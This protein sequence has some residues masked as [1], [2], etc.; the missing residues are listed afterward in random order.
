MADW[1]KI[2]DRYIS[3]EISLAQLAREEGVSCTT[4]RA[5]AKREDW[6]QLRSEKREDSC[7]Q[8]FERV[9]EK[10]L[11]KTEQIIDECESLTSGE[12]KAITSALKELKALREQ[13]DEQ[14]GGAGKLEI[15]FTDEAEELSR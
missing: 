2:K 9:T 10:L 15:C 12:I 14:R 1:A 3:G 7:K 4:L 8:R 5:R 11:K 13:E 6:Q